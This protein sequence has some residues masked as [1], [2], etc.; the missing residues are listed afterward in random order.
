MADFCYQ[1]TADLFGAEYAPNNDMAGIAKPDYMVGVLC[2]GCSGWVF[3]DSEG[4]CLD[5]YVCELARSA[6][7]LA[8]NGSY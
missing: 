1:C 3:V 5:H 2:E 6:Y 7:T 8:G 4:K